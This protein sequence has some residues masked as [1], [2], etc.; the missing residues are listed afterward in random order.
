MK[1][2]KNIWHWIVSLFDGKDEYD[3]LQD[4]L[5]ALKDNK[6]KFEKARKEFLSKLPNK[7]KLYVYLKERGYTGQQAYQKVPTIEI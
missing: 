2:L 6:E 1:T 4:K 3:K 7:A 5:D